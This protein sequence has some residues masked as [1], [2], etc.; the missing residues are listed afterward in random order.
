MNARP[1]NAE[2]TRRAILDTARHLFAKQGI[3]TVSLRDIASEAGVSHG[4]IQQYFG[5]REDMVA[6]IIKGEI[7]AFMATAAPPP[8]V[9]MEHLR[10]VLQDRMDDFRDF[11]LIIMRAELAGIEPEKMID[12]AA[13]TPAMHLASFIGD[14]QAK[15]SSCEGPALDPQL[16]S[17]YVN[18]AL[19]GFSAMAPWLMTTVGLDPEEYQKRNEEIG[20]ITLALIELACGIPHQ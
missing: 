17:A 5:T 3:S 18:A 13:T 16:V 12:P 6:A 11:G 15:R 14:Q 4:L 8:D 20:K 1:R 10:R 19:F 2:L 7:D 9:N